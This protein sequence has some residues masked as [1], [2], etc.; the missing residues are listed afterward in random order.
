MAA[1]PPTTNWTYGQ[2]WHGNQ[3]FGKCFGH[4]GHGYTIANSD[5]SFG[6]CWKDPKFGQIAM[7]KKIGE[8]SR[9]HC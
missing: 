9:K 3:W 6:W 7:L 5:A 4:V 1:L 2:L 8:Q